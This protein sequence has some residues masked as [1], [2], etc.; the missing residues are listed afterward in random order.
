MNKSKRQ[1]RNQDDAARPVEQGVKPA[2]TGKKGRDEENRIVD[3]DQS[4]HVAG[5]GFGFWGEIPK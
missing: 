1:H 3:R 4:R 5:D 2:K